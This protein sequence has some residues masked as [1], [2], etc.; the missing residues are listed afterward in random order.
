MSRRL[1]LLLVTDR[2]CPNKGKWLTWPSFELGMKGQVP[3]PAH[4]VRMQWGTEVSYFCFDWPHSHLSVSEW[5]PSEEPEWG[6][7]CIYTKPLQLLKNDLSPC[8]PSQSSSLVR[9]VHFKPPKLLGY[10]SPLQIPPYIL[11]KYL[12]ENNPCV[13]IPSKFQPSLNLGVWWLCW[14]KI[15]SK[16]M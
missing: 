9:C 3:R 1:V 2:R 13:L 6:N 14:Q 4:Q 10:I 5:H 8:S 11:Q 15:R 12:Q 7:G 16:T